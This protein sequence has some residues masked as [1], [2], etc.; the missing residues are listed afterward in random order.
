MCVSACARMQIHVD[1]FERGAGGWGGHFWLVL[2]G[3]PALRS[4]REQEGLK[5]NYISRPSQNKCQALMEAD[6]GSS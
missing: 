3:T 2:V 1:V 6:R 5:V 4:G